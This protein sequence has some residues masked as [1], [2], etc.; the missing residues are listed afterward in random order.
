M[1]FTTW[2]CKRITR[3]WTKQQAVIGLACSPVEVVVNRLSQKLTD[4]HYGAIIKGCEQVRLR[5]VWVRRLA[6][7]LWVCEVDKAKPFSP[8]RDRINTIPQIT[9][10]EIINYYFDKKGK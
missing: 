2:F 1:V 9:L 7:T 3:P 5:E 10:V 8:P 6:D 4:L